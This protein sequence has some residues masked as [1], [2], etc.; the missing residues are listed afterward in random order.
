[1]E[2]VML[3]VDIIDYAPEY[4]ADFARLN[5][6]WMNTYFGKKMD[7]HLDNPEET[8]ILKGGFVL[9]AKANDEIVGTCAILKETNKLYEIADM[10]VSPQH[11]G[12]HIGKRLLS[13]AVESVRRMGARHVYLVTSSKLA[14]SIALYRTY[15]FKEMGIADMETSVYEGSDV[16]MVLNLK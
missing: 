11:R 2:A 12:K 15:G 9:F 6:D 1:M 7:A 13:A 5:A 14:A 3:N 8:I 10:V 16:K 4:R